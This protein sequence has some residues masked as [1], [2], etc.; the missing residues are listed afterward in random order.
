MATVGNLAKKMVTVPQQL[1]LGSL[2]P[3]KSSCENSSV[4]LNV[5]PVFDWYY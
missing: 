3:E 5:H 2:L 1:F 4:T